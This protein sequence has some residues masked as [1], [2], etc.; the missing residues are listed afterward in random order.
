MFD[1]VQRVILENTFWNVGKIYVAKLFHY[2]ANA[3]YTYN[4]NIH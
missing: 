2:N 1:K 4:W 3:A